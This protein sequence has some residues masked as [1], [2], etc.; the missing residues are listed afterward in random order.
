MR[1]RKGLTVSVRLGAYFRVGLQGSGVDPADNV[2]AFHGFHP[3]A[4][5]EIL[6]PKG[7]G[8]LPLKSQS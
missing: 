3:A 4:A 6:N 8:L 5:M 7:L 2:Q 1:L